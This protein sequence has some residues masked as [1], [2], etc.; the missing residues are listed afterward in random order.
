MPKARN[1]HRSERLH[2]LYAS[3]CEPWNLVHLLIQRSLVRRLLIRVGKPIADQL[4]NGWATGIV[5]SWP[6]P[7]CGQSA[8]AVGAL[9]TRYC[10][11]LQQAGL[12]GLCAHVEVLA[13]RATWRVAGLIY[14]L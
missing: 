3:H 6:N 2:A 9:E 13:Q 8:V 4:A 12:V 7:F 14:P 5:Q 10:K 11:K 1:K